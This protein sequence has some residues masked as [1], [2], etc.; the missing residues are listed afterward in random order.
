MHSDDIKN[1][2]QLSLQDSNFDYPV[3]FIPLILLFSQSSVAVTWIELQN[4]QDSQF[5]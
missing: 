5:G 1:S 4:Q 2:I 3:S